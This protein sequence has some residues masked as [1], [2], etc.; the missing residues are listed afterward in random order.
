MQLSSRGGCPVGRG[1][2]AS[3][4]PAMPAHALR[5]L[6]GVAG[7]RRRGP[8]APQ[9]RCRA[10]PMALEWVAADARAAGGV[11]RVGVGTLA[12]PTGFTCQHHNQR[13]G[14]CPRE[15]QSMGSVRMWAPLRSGGGRLRMRRT[16]RAGLPN[17][18]G[19]P[20]RGAF[21]RIGS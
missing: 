20:R 14:K 9:A 2:A 16:E 10:L 21:K 15:C 1:L 19:G 12:H 13:Q 18:M 11:W 4:A 3:H 6:R 5:H 8:G 7:G 17:V